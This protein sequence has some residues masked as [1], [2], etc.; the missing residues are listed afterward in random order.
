MVRRL[1]RIWTFEACLPYFVRLETDRD[2]TGAYHGSDGSDPRQSRAP[3]AVGPTQPGV[4]RGVPGSRIPRLSRLQRAGCLGRRAGAGEYRPGGALQLGG[5]LPDARARAVEPDG[6]GAR[7]GAH[8]WCFA[9]QTVTGVEVEIDGQLVCWRATRS[10]SPPDR[11]FSPHLL[12]LSGIGPEA[13]LGAMGIHA[14]GGPRRGRPE[15]TRSS[16]AV[17]VVG[18]QQRSPAADR[19]TRY[20]R[21]GWPAR[22]R[23]P[24][25]TIRTTC[26][27]SAF[28]P[29][30]RI[31][32]EFRFR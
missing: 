32:S 2:F 8:G 13:H 22:H 23:R 9:R 26:A 6:A 27:W 10:S 29:R 1:I 30:A 18:G 16:G 19:R 4:P 24:G 11:V 12:L 31:A 15:R 20:A 5:R 14:A 21:P 17:R 25:L 3:G 7:A 28:G